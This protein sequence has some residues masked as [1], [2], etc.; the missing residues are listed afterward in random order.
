MCPH[1][2]QYTILAFADK[3]LHKHLDWVVKVL[4]DSQAS[5]T[6]EIAEGGKKSPGT[7]KARFGSE[8]WRNQPEGWPAGPTALGI[9]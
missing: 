9:A 6:N 8:F 4:C 5:V 1:A 7:E 2:A 3:A